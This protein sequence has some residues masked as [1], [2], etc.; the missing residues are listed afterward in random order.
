MRIRPYRTADNRIDGAVLTL[1][2]VTDAEEALRLLLEDTPDFILDIEP[3]GRV[4]FINRTLV[5]LAR[6]VETGANFLDYLKPK[7][8]PA[9]RACLE[10]VARTGTTAE[11]RTQGVAGKDPGQR[12]AT[13][14]SAVKK[15]GVIR[16]LAVKT[17]GPAL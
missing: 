12:M 8:K 3:L 17:G 4:L 15:D 14:V 1:V 7:G 9:A 2:D 11:F 16:A 10:R 13:R 6:E 5:S